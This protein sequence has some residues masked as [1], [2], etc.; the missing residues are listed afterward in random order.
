MGIM[1]QMAL[2]FVAVMALAACGGGGGGGGSAAADPS[3]KLLGNF[4]FQYSLSGSTYSDRYTFDTKLEDTT[5][6]GTPF[7][8]GHDADHSA[9]AAVGAWLPSLSKYLVVANTALN[10]IYWVY[11]FVIEGDGRLTGCLDYMLSGS[12]TGF[13]TAFDSTASR[14]YDSSSWG[15]AAAFFAEGAENRYDAFMREAS[16]MR[17]ESP[18]DDRVRQAAAELAARL[19]R[20]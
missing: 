10:D 16:P 1:R 3:D 5:S 4:I 9:Y 18:G 12:L 11:S 14:R 8:G 20:R 7:Y 17:M 13:C 2:A 6:D 15:R 19:E